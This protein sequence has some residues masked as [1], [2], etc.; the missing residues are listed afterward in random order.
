VTEAVTTQEV[1]IR[2]AVEGMS[3][4]RSIRF[5]LDYLA[6]HGVPIEELVL[7]LV[8]DYYSRV[9]A[10]AAHLRDFDEEDDE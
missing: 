10:Y 5:E 3:D 7:Y 9:D 1:L 6:S 2:R 8:D 4:P